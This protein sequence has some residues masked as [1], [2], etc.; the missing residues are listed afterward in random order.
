MEIEKALMK[1]VLIKIAYLSKSKH[2]V[3]KIMFPN[4]SAYVCNLIYQLNKVID[5]NVISLGFK[6]KINT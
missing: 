6:W 5:V 3:M 2:N 4:E 1:Q